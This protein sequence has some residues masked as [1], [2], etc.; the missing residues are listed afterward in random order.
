MEQEQSDKAAPGLFRKI[1]HMSVAERIKLAMHGNK[2]ARELL[3]RDSNGVVVRA[4]LMNPRITEDEILRLS[5]SRSLSTEILRDIALNDEWLENYHIRLELVRN[6]KTPVPSSLKLM[7]R[8][9]EQDL[10]RLAES[11]NIPAVLR[12]AARRSQE[13][14]GRS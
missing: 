4:V 10:K 13:K 2:E 9:N 12:T 8:L 3:A 7:K 1:K 5:A 14:G 11:K 6:P